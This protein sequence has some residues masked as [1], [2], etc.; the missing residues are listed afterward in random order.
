[1][2]RHAKASS[3][4]STLRRG[5]GT[6]RIFRG[7]VL[8]GDG[9][10]APSQRVTLVAL[11]MIVATVAALTV[12][13]TASASKEAFN[14]FGTLSGGENNGRGSFAGDFS[15]PR[16]IAV[17]TTGVGAP[18]GT[19]YVADDG[20]NRIQRFDKNA[21]FVSAWGKDVIASTVNE[22]QRLVFQATGG[23]FTL[24]F[25]GATTGPIKYEGGNGISFAIDNALGA[26]PT[27]GGAANVTVVGF[28]TRTAPY[29]ITFTGPLGA[30]DQPQLSADT[31]QLDG[32]LKISTVADGTAATAST[33]TGFEVCTIARECKAGVASGGDGTPAGNGALDAPQAVAVDGDTG[34]VYVSDRN[35]RRINAYDAS[36]DFLFS[37]GRDVSEPDGGTAVEICSDATDT[38]RAG[39]SGSGPG[40]IGSGTAGGTFGIAVSPPDGNAATGSVFLADSGNN[41]IQRFDLSGN[42]VEAAGTAGT[43]PGQFGS[44][45]PRTIAVDSR[46]IVYASDSSNRSEVERYDSLDANGVGVGFLAPIVPAVNE[47]QTITFTNFVNLPGTEKDFT[48]TCPDGATTDAITYASGPEGAADRIAK[49]LE[50]T[51]GGNVTVTGTG[52]YPDPT[53]TMTV[54][55]EGSFA[56]SDVPTTLCTSLVGNGSACSVTAEIDGAPGP[57]QAGHSFA[58]GEATLG[59]AVDPD[60]DGPG[61]DEDVLYVLRGAPLGDSAVVQQLGPANDPGLTAPPTAADDRHG[62]GL[63]FSTFGP[64]GLGLDDVSG[65]LYVSATAA[66][67]AFVHR[68]YMLGTIPAPVLTL[69][70]ITT[71]TD[72][73]AT[74]SGSVD[75]TGGLVECKFEYSTDQS[76]WVD[77]AEAECGDLDPNGGSQAIGESVT[78]LDPATKYFVRLQVTRTLDSSSVTTSSV[79][80]FETD[81]VPPAVSDLG[82]IQIADTSARLIG[83]V[84]PRHS[85]TG[86]V[87]E[88]GTTP[89]LGSSTA[90]V[91]IGGGTAPIT[92]SQVV[93]GLSKDTDYWFRLVATN[94][95]GT[96]HSPSK[97]FHTRTVPLPP[98]NPGSCANE[99]IRKAQA[100][101]YLPDCRAYE[102]VS[103]PDKNQGGVD[104]GGEFGLKLLSVSRDGN[105]AAFCSTALFGDPPS[106]QGFKCAPYVSRRGPGGWATSD[107]FPR[108]CPR[109]INGVGVGWQKTILSPDFDH[110]IVQHPE[111]EACEVSP[112]PLDP[113]ATL[114]GHNLYVQ[115]LTADSDYQL[116]SPHHPG[117][118]GGFGSPTAVAGDDDF[119]HVLYA[120][121]TNQTE[122]PDSPSSSTSFS[123]LYQ[124]AQPGPDCTPST[125]SYDAG[126]DGCLSLISKDPTGAPFTV[127]SGVP[128]DIGNGFEVMPGVVSADGKRVYFGSSSAGD[129][130]TPLAQ[131]LRDACELY[132]REN[133]IQPQSPISGG[134]CTDET[135]ACTYHVSASECTVACGSNSSG[136]HF[137]WASPDGSVAL[138]ESCAKLT[139]ASAGSASGCSA[140]SSDINAADAYKL[141]RWDRNAPPGNRLIDLSVDHEPAA[142]DLTPQQGNPLA[143]NQPHALDAIGV[144]A[145]EGAA[146]GNDAAPGNTVYFVAA[147]QIVANEPTGRNL[148]LYRWTYDGG[149]PRVE[150][151]GPYAPATSIGF[152]GGAI[153][154]KTGLTVNSLVLDNNADRYH[155]TTTPDGRYLTIQT[156]LRYDPAADRDANADI[157]RW[158][159]A[160]GWTCVSCQPPGAPSAGD[161]NSIL[162]RL[163]GLEEPNSRAPKVLMSDDGK[164]IFFSTPDAL[165]PADVNG[166]PGCPIVFDGGAGAIG[167]I[168][169]CDDVYEWNDGTVSLITAGIGTKPF[170]F[171]GATGTGDEVF[172]FTAQRLVGWDLDLGADVY[173][174]RVDGGFP[175][176]PVQ[177][178]VCE[179]EGCRG[180]GTGTPAPAGAG[181][182]V[183]EGPGD[184]PTR[185]T[186]RCR[187]NL[188]KRN[189]RCVKKK[190]RAGHK[191][192]GRTRAANH[193]RRVER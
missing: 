40:E 60:S 88:Y 89:A 145:D 1:M 125:P 150:Y 104:Q 78:G 24:S 169:S 189:G 149:S 129:A 61:P 4:G 17:N 8:A 156:V 142:G 32:T 109:D 63:G 113:A 188:V 143:G 26:L 43:G 65:R 108:Y 27:V 3:A 28:G 147:G 164:R 80:F 181:T 124:W 84:D 192:N 94:L 177:P 81:G 137:V 106:E 21:K 102:M 191:R 172:F 12:A 101:T 58:P 54:I 167:V 99:A 10:G 7:A 162:V 133:G 41:R 175:E 176:P 85:A 130:F 122:P 126:I 9:S 56:G 71:K 153:G 107:P 22:R 38:C 2:R 168:R 123:R 87:F 166:E 75:P 34:N 48:L 163:P 67:I 148:K 98:V 20:N 105:A 30:S 5:A 95:V 92:V 6:A 45:Q 83:T 183:F 47:T 121:E 66:P 33:G 70:A 120:S 151:L 184:A 186:K 115:D 157:Y 131:C 179:G 134:E 23:T 57:L 64:Q 173:S 111:T 144:S 193:D 116:L 82:V 170:V 97:T 62:A 68:V 73:T 11:S 128:A 136:D 100:S 46:G 178:P 76:L 185:S 190:R 139:D 74:F 37:V 90:P 187:A 132:M 59:M 44:N 50:K 16:G 35:N 55:F 159:E 36:G 52:D 114:G 72:S 158:S 77:V 138:F 69:N 112:T 79:K 141:Y 152:G 19:I 86:Y 180:P 93:N 42:F 127:D 53:R 174:A 25:N 118:F 49:A 117:Y 135:L 15:D 14:Y 31:G 13:G 161:V 91:S 110:A 182:A 103:P 96:T 171:M 51:C 119:S 155:A 18:Q 39:D 140:G 165:V 160:D 154:F 146:P 29:V